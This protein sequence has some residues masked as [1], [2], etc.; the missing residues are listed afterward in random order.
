[1]CLFVATSSY[2]SN[3]SVQ[4]LLKSLS[5]VLE[6]DQTPLFLL[7]ITQWLIV[8]FHSKYHIDAEIIYCYAE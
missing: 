7:S 1:M 8:M 6:L 3:C 5:T 2:C 4:L